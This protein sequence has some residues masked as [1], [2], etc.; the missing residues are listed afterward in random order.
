MPSLLTYYVANKSDKHSGEKVRIQ[1]TPLSLHFFST[2][3][4]LKTQKNKN[5]ESVGYIF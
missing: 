1:K 2:R 5:I 4:F 3:T